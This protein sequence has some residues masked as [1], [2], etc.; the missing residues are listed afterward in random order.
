[1]LD[2]IQDNY[3]NRNLAGIVLL[4]DGIVN[5]GL[6]PLYTE[7]TTPVF[8]IG[9]G[10]TSVKKDLK[11]NHVRYNKIA[12]AGN[13][14]PVRAEVE[15]YGLKGEAKV[16]LK[17]GAVVIDT[18]TI[19]LDGKSQITEVDFLVN[20]E[21]PGL[22]H[23]TVEAEI[24]PGEFSKKNNVAHAYIDVINGKEKILIVAFSPHPDIKALRS[25]LEEKEN[26]EVEVHI[27]GINKLKPEKYDLVIFH[28]LPDNRNAHKA[29]VDQLMKD[30]KSH[31]F[32]VAS[33]TQTSIFNQLNPIVTIEASNQKD[34]VIAGLS[35]DFEKF[36]IDPEYS[37]LISSYPPVTVPFGEYSLKGNIDVLLYQKIGSVVSD[38]PLLATSIKDGKKT[39]VF[40]GDGLWRWRLNEYRE[41]EKTE[42]FDNIFSSLIQY[43]SAKED[44][45]KFRVYPEKNEFRESDRVVFETELYNDVFERVYNNKVDLAIRDEGGKVKKYSFTPTEA[46]TTFE[47][48]GLSP[49][50]YKYSASTEFAEKTE[51]ASG[52]FIITEEVLEAVNLTANFNLLR[53]LSSKSG[54]SFIP[55]GKVSQ[56]PSI[57]NLSQKQSIIHSNEEYQ[58]LINLPWIFAVILVLVTLEWGL[59]KYSG[60]Y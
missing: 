10:D 34:Q 9:I 41:T 42:A 38:N 25:A 2:R 22:Q 26:Y 15:N 52:E 32:I 8:C 27:P 43:L 56:L 6:D 31:F 21:K 4:S 57:M 12:Y 54:G 37:K 47:V 40:V 1:M 19:K 29:L 46:S 55:T 5:E 24:L 51:R 35:H 30:V 36:K 11:I 33:Q 28:N 16:A 13:K 53:E 14:F 7:Y 45:R 60:G 50:L 59:R 18:K 44:K 48:K 23:Y 39:A 20:P 3:E 17:K 58:E 49:G